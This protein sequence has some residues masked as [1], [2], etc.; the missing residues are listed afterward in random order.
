MCQ[1]YVS[2]MSVEEQQSSKVCA[3]EC[4]IC[5]SVIVAQIGIGMPVLYTI[6]LVIDNMADTTRTS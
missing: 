5:L 4:L 3:S 2:D 6:S 1:R